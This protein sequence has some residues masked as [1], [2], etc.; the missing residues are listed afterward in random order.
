MFVSAFKAAHSFSGI[1]VPK[2]HLS[3]NAINAERTSSDESTNYNYI[4]LNTNGDAPYVPSGMS[5]EQYKQI[6]DDEATKMQRMDFGAWGPRFRQTDTPVGDW[7]VQTNLWVKGFQAGGPRS[8]AALSKE[9]VARQATRQELFVTARNAVVSFLL[10]YAVLDILLFSF[11]SIRSASTSKRLF[12]SILTRQGILHSMRQHFLATVLFG[13]LQFL[14]V[15]LASSTVSLVTEYRENSYRKLWPKRR[16]FGTPMF[17]S[18]LVVTVKMALEM[19][20]SLV[21]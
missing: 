7:M 6:K 13:K 8:S 12:L 4:G 21:R 19:G 5:P 17:A 1:P 3:L 10:A 16:I 15:A 14:K 18:L 2:L 9:E 11:A 20:L